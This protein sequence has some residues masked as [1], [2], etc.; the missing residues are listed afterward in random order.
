MNWDQYQNNQLYLLTQFSATVLLFT[1]FQPK[2]KVAFFI[3]L[4]FQEM[5][6]FLFICQRLIWIYYFFNG[7]QSWFFG[8]IISYINIISSFRFDLNWNI[9]HHR[10]TK[11]IKEIEKKLVDSKFMIVNLADWICYDNKVGWENQ[12]CQIWDLDLN[13]WI[14][15]PPSAS[16][17]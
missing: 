10:K 12:I 6:I 9:L 3:H 17:Q 11:K 8:K 15:M 1:A 2:R 5:F 7:L 14:W 16:D 13:A 4:S